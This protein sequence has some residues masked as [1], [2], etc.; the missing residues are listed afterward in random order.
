MT[1]D[2]ITILK[3]RHQMQREAALLL[4]VQDIV[5]R[6]WSS[7]GIEQYESERIERMNRWAGR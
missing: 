5:H 2:A 3:R 4:F 7:L 6:W 1:M